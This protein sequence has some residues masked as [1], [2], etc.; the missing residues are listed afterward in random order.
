MDK[1]DNSSEIQPETVLLEGF[2]C[3]FLR[4]LISF[5]QHFRGT[6]ALSVEK[7]NGFMPPY[8]C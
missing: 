4:L 5:D 2:F 8:L 6:L 1:T 7:E 3:M